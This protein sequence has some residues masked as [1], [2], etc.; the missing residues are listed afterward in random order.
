MKLMK[1]PVVGIRTENTDR[2]LPSRKIA[3]AATSTVNGDA[4]PDTA[5]IPAKL[6]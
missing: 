3:T 4:I 1:E 2:V 5:T 6:K